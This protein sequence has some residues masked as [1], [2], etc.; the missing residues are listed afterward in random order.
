MPSPTTL[1]Q[2]FQL[3]SL[4]DTWFLV[5]LENKMPRVNKRTEKGGPHGPSTQVSLPL[6]LLT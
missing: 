5:Q 6:G 4:L 1:S 2:L 3:P